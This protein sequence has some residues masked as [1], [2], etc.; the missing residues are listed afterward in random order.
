M[1]EISD[2]RVAVITK[3]LCFAYLNSKP[4]INGIDITVKK[5]NIYGLLGPSGCGKT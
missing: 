2:N 4:I 5:A 3:D 1:C